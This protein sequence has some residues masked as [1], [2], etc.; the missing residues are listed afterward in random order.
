MVS[1][2][3][4]DEYVLHGN[5]ERIA[6]LRQ[7]A[8]ALQ[9]TD[10]Q[11][12]AYCL[13]S[14][15]VHLVVI[16][17]DEPL[18]RLFKPLHTGFARWANQR[19]AR[20]GLGARGPVFAERPRTVLLEEEAYLQEVVRYVHNNPVRAGL[21][22]HAS[23]SKWSS[24][25]A[26]VGQVEPPRWLNVGYVLERFGADA[27]RARRAFDEFVRAGEREP[28]R[29]EL[30]GVADAEALRRVRATLSDAYRLSDGV[31]GSEAF[32]ARVAQDARAARETLNRG[33]LHV[34]RNAWELRR[35]A[36]GDV[37]TQVLQALNLDAVEFTERPQATRG[38]LAR[39]LI[40][41]IWVHHLGGRQVEVARE[42]SAPTYAVA[43][44]YGN[45]VRT[46]HHLE[47]LAEAVLHATTR[48]PQTRDTA[49]R[50][51]SPRLR[52]QVEL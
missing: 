11:L 32:A 30:S 22:A 34:A 17:G 4:R 19:A 41:W 44:W 48:Q 28:R 51:T 20:E 1:R 23:A 40:A 47:E 21:V 29:P 38:H 3:V 52:Y 13:M 15:H 24:H 31:L 45:A 42:L 9:R 33:R 36:L 10:A 6:Y 43:R 7:L 25:A 14:N 2:F 8:N 26:Y 46:A 35:P 39:Q 50:R 18:E 16:Q 12:L 5:T 37:V 49:V 27:A